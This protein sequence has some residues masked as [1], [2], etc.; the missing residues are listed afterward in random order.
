LNR[1]HRWAKIAKNWRGKIRDFWKKQVDEV[2]K[3]IIFLQGF[4]LF[5][6]ERQCFMGVRRFVFGKI[7]SKIKSG[8]EKDFAARPP[9]TTLGI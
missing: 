6:F 1:R 8:I 4:R 5:G 2:E 3:M 9:H 7:I